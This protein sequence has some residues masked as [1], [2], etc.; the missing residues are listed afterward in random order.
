MCPQRSLSR[1]MWCPP[2]LPR[3][4]EGRAGPCQGAGLPLEGGMAF[5]LCLFVGPGSPSPPPPPTPG[6]CPEDR[7]DGGAS[8][9]WGGG[10][11]LAA[12]V[13]ALPLASALPCSLGWAMKGVEGCLLP[14][15]PPH[16]RC[17]DYPTCS[18]DCPGTVVLFLTLSLVVSKLIRLGI[19]LQ[20]L[21][22]PS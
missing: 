5:P 6:S 21:A 13:M 2:A 10:S 11:V 12:G 18:G 4:L 14:R 19:Y 7:L 9:T 20:R 22:Q 1:R 3:E 15:P 8:R 16:L 17:C